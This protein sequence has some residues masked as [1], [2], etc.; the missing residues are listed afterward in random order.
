[1]PRAVAATIFSSRSSVKNNA[2]AA[3]FETRAISLSIDAVDPEPEHIRQLRRADDDPIAVVQRD[4]A[5]VGIR[6]HA[7]VRHAREKQVTE[8]ILGRSGQS[9]WAE[10]LHGSVINDVVRRAEGIDVHI[11]ADR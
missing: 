8:I 7:L 4:V 1:M 2:S 11:V 9:R 10:L 5:A 6:P 3:R